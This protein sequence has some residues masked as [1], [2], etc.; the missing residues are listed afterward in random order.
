MAPQAPT[1][2]IGGF[3]SLLGGMHA[4]IEPEVLAE[5]AYSRGINV[6]SRGGLV[7]TRPGFTK[8]VSL[9]AGVFQGMAA[10]S[11]RDASRLV[12]VKGG[13]LLVID[14][15]TGVITDMGLRFPGD[16][17]CYL[18]SMERFFLIQDT[19]NPAVVLRV[20][21]GQVYDTRIEDSTVQL[22]AQIPIG[23]CFAFAHARLHMSPVTIPGS[24]EGGRSN[25]VSGDVL[26]P[27]DPQ[28]C[29][30]AFSEDG[31]LNEG[32]A[33]SLPMEMG[34]ITALAPLR[35]AATGTGYGGL[36][37]FAERGVAAFDMSIARDQWADSALGQ[38]LFFGSGTVSPWSVIPVN[39]T[40][41]YRA[42]DGLRILSYAVTSKQSAGDVLSSVPQSS[43]VG[44]FFQSDDAAFLPWVSAAAAG[45]RVFMTVGGTV[46]N[47][48]K[49]LVVL[50]TARITDVGSPQSTPSYDGIW[51]IQG[52]KFMGIASAWRQS[53]ETLYAVLDDDYLWYLDED[54]TVDS[55]ALPI[56]C[57]L[58]TR[59]LLL[60]SPNHKRLSQL[61]LWLKGLEQDTEIKLY[62]RPMGYPLWDPRG[63]LSL[64]VPAGSLPQCRRALSL[65]V[66]RE[67][68]QADPQSSEPLILGQGHQFCLEWN[69]ALVIEMFRVIAEF[70]EEPAPQ[71]CPETESIPLTVA[72][73]VNL[74]EY[75]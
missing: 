8:S 9:G 59:T 1:V 31:Y 30:G 46:G 20:A 33:H 47:S 14:T 66:S 54:S 44:P 61:Q 6:T 19:V 28:S 68:S 74:G 5:T 10:W 23:A 40:L 3:V 72:D 16:R 69:G 39:G 24:T 2:P 36:V 32:G 34:Y 42:V 18:G 45:N 63:T 71:P 52:R 67:D 62:S 49:A 41:I 15:G 70:I 27:V 73:G 43:E 26:K 17:Q 21:G 56:Q 64:K 58:M 7:Q 57:R 37:V 75:L 55:E 29:L 4:G 53:V 25:F 50:D 51:Q 60:D 11:L 65:A 35:N 13:H 22:G 12:V 48:F 38:I